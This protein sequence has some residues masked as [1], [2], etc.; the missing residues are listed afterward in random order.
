VPGIQP[1]PAD[2]LRRLTRRVWD[3]MAYGLRSDRDTGVT[4]GPECDVSVTFDL[5]EA[6][7]FGRV[8]DDVVSFVRR[9]RVSN[10]LPFTSRSY[11]PRCRQP[12]LHP[13]TEVMKAPAALSIE[14]SIY[15]H[16]SGAVI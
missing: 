3:G 4:F 5:T 1:Y 15:L 13:R 11:G 16:W 10:A 2:V 14:S 7:A 8:R 9:Q 12:G 6:T